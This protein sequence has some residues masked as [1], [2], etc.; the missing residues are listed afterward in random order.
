M[1]H[2]TP[3]IPFPASSDAPPRPDPIPRNVVLRSQVPGQHSVR[4][5][6]YDAEGVIV[7]A[8]EVDLTRPN[9][10]DR[11]AMYTRVLLREVLNLPAPAVKVPPMGLFLVP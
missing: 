2:S 4:L 6:S 5:S 11:I 10:E 3:T 8:I 1:A 7:D 9:P